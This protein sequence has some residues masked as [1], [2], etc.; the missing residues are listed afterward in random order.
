MQHSNAS[1]TDMYSQL[2]S[3]GVQTRI[4]QGPLSQ[5]NVEAMGVSL[6]QKQCHVVSL[7]VGRMLVYSSQGV[8]HKNI[9]DALHFQWLDKPPQCTQLGLDR[10]RTVR[11]AWMLLRSSMMLLRLARQTTRICMSSSRCLG[12]SCRYPCTWM[13]VC[14]TLLRS[15]GNQ[16]NQMNRGKEQVIFK[17]RRYNLLGAGVKEIQMWVFQ[18]Q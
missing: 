3:R 2:F 5:N 10:A 13:R 18:V 4:R 16:P 8:P 9:I 1:V 6:L 11:N 12:V 17:R 7:A 14:D 15:L